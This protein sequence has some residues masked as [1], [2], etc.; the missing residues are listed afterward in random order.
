VPEGWL[1]GRSTPTD[2]SNLQAGDADG[3]QCDVCH[4]LTNPDGSEH[5]GVQVAPFIAN[6]ERTPPTGYYGTA[7]SVLSDGS[8]KL[9]PYSDAEARHQFLP[10][11]FHRSVDFCGTCHDVSNPVVGDLAHN[12]GAQVPLAPGT[13][14][15]VPGSPVAG[16]AAFNNFPYQ[17]GVV[18]RTYSEHKASLLSQTLVSSFAT[19]PVELQ[20]GAL[21]KTYQA[22]TLAGTG[23]NYADGTPRYFS[24]QSCHMRP[25]IGQ[26]CNKNPPLRTDLPVHDQ[27]GANY[28]APAAIQWLDAAGKLRLGGGLTPDQIG[29]MNLGA[30][31]A[32]QNLD[33]A[34]RLS[35]T[36][37]LLRV[38]NLTGHKLITGYPEGR[39]MWIGIRWLD[40]SGVLL[41]EDGAYG[42]IEVMIDGSPVVV[43]TLLDLEGHYTRVYEAHGALT[44]E[45]A[46]QLLAL[47]VSPAL[48]LAFD[49]VT[50]AVTHTLGQLG[51]QAPGSHQESFHFVVNNKV[52]K[53]NRIPPWGMAYDK[54]RERNILPVPAT[55]FGNPGPGGTYRYWD[56]VPLNPPFGAHHAEIAL[57][58]QPTSWEYIQFLDRAN[59]GNVA[60]LAA[61]GRN[62]LDAWLSTGMAEPYTMATVSW[63]S[64]VPACSD[65]INNDGDGFSD[66]ADPGC[67]ASAGAFE[68]D[69]DGVA[70]PADNCAGVPNAD[71]ANFDADALGDVCDPDDDQDGLLDPV[72]TDTGIYLSADDTGS[73]PLDPDSDD[74]G[75]R[76]GV[77]VAAG[78]D[79]NDP[80][81]VPAIAVPALSGR[82]LALLVGCFAALT[83]LRLR[84][85][86]PADQ[87]A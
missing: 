32:K 83:L 2:G 45:W 37:N 64:V 78:S 3:V 38:V 75:F 69:R 16:K 59:T 67:V 33:D 68:D 40:S 87:S 8:A 86:P 41:A 21:L 14:S 12:N 11:A 29:A 80:A 20:T 17:Y 13:F 52:V 46:A 55:Q 48:P 65:G 73:D 82:V 54:A 15:G 70:D 4:R 28:W 57:R 19:L 76:D 26:G 22:A 27:T 61:E 81:S 42:P 18:E 85:R 51:A 36:G 84:R 10:S 35:V 1:A 44:Q 24:C 50:G 6:D 43:Q 5:A 25:V 66:G 72:E 34:A 49:R 56:E 30:L 31:R 47:G 9:G 74:D 63:N 60:F 71:Q 58:Y 7:Q 79:P 62:L 53:D 23:G 77:E 39:R